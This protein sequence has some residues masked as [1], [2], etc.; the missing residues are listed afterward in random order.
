MHAVNP[1]MDLINL[2][3]ITL[4]CFIAGNAFFVSIC[5]TFSYT[6]LPVYELEIALH[7]TFGP[8]RYWAASK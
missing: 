2:F 6:R 7:I 5:V 1:G 8:A 3:E 4:F